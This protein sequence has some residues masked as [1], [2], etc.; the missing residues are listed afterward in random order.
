MKKNLGATHALRAVFAIRDKILS[1]QYSPGDR[2]GEVA[3]AEELNISRTPVRDALSHLAGEGMLERA[4]TGGFVIRDFGFDD[5]ADSIELRGIL[6]GTVARLAAERGASKV[7]MNKLDKIIL[8]IDECFDTE[9]FKVNRTLYAERNAEFHEEFGKLSGSE[10]MEREL[11]R[12]M[13]MPFASPSAFLSNKKES[14][15]YYLELCTAQQQHRDILLAIAKGQGTRAEAI[16]RA[17][18]NLAMVSL[19]ETLAI[20]PLKFTSQNSKSK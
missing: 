9:K 13:K 7:R 8:S 2:L 11:S 10:V 3:I 6:E 20:N 15:A 1:G 16:A 18:A 17:H 5:I 14:R 4:S 12:V 19:G